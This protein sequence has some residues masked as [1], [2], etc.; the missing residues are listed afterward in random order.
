MLALKRIIFPII[1]SIMFFINQAYGIDENKIV[2]TSFTGKSYSDNPK[3]ISEKLHELSPEFEIVWLFNNPEEKKLVVPSYIKC[4]HIYS[5][6]ALKELATSKFWVD[7][8][9]K[10]IYMYKSK[11]QFYI[12]TSHGDRGFKK[13]LYDSPFVSKDVKY[14]ES[15]I[16]DLAISG[17]NYADS[18]YKTAFHYYGEILKVGCP[19]N[20]ILVEN[21]KIKANEIRERL[22][23]TENMKVVLFAPTLRREAANQNMNQLTYGIDWDETLSTLESKTH[24]NW[25]CLFR[26]HS[27]VKGLS[28]IPNDERFIDVTYYEDMNELLLVSDFLITDYSSSAGDFALLN[29]LIILFQNDR[30]EYL[31]KDRDF[32]FNIDESPYI[33]AFNQSDINNIIEKMDKDTISKN[34]KDILDFYGTI[35][36]GEASKA[37]VEYIN[38]KK[39]I[40]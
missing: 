22:K 5:L 8:F 37:V 1:K 13:I 14:I 21:S 12:Q 24:S 33:V 19:R 3:A 9:C 7:N 6:K 23:I 26:A 31:E 32:Y 25:V 27:A 39:Y 40:N 15:E 20:D 18:V 10:H 4:V 29:R 30:A 17:S 11:K 28:G 36:K 34:C 38:S 35:E 16:C 2:F